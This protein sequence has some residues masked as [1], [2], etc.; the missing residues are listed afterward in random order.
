MTEY[1]QVFSP[2]QLRAL[3]IAARVSACLSLAGSSFT[4][5]S[6][7]SYPPLR[8]PVNRLAFSIAVANIFACLSYSWGRYPVK[9]GRNSAFCQTQGFF[10]T[11]FVMTDPLLV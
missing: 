4:I 7:I 8:K 3:D 9:A 10:I 2:D 1:K 11:W 6:F 5:V